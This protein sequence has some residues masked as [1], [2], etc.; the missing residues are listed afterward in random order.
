MAHTKLQVLIAT[1]SR[2]VENIAPSALP[3]VDGVEYVITCQNPEG[4]DID[5]S[6]LAGRSDVKVFFFDDKNVSRNRNHGIDLATADYI[7]FSDD[8]INHDAAALVEL[9]ATFDAD[10]SLD[11]V[12]TH[13]IIPERH[14]YPPDSHDLRS[15]WRYYSPISFEIAVRRKSLVDSG[16]R[17]CEIISIGTDCLQAGEENFFYR[18]C[19]NAGFRGIF[20][21]IAVS[22][23]SGLTTC[24]HSAAK[25]GVIRAKG[26][27]MPFDR[28]AFAAL[29]RLPV[30]A[31]RSPL[32]FFKALYYLVQGYVY[33]FKHKSEL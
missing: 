4:L 8:D 30:E 26:A 14:V 17:F 21:D 31:W 7:L 25:P 33:Y 15:T 5:M 28:G 13:A 20:R 29:V 24:S 2:R 22:E 32:P 23:H 11:M 12:T 16:I 6:A 27:F 1:Y 10:D 9:I 3:V 19:L 18:H